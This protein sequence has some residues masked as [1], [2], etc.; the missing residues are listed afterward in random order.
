MVNAKIIVK[1]HQVPSISAFTAVCCCWKL[2]SNK[3]NMSFAFPIDRTRSW[4]LAKQGKH[5]GWSAMYMASAR[6]LIHIIVLLSP[7]ILTFKFATAKRW[8][9]PLNIGGRWIEGSNTAVYWRIIRDFGK[10]L[11]NR[12]WPLNRWPL[13]GGPTVFGHALCTTC[14]V[15]N[16]TPPDI[17]ELISRWQS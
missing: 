8:P 13:N 9:R 3:R 15:T 6:L 16:L 4:W 7:K 5:Q 17:L 10:C 2:S 1:R 11:L 14:D 12:G